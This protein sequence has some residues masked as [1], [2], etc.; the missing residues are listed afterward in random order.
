MDSAFA[1]L[2]KALLRPFSERPQDFSQAALLLFEV[3]ADSRHR[4]ADP[5]DEQRS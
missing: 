1:G 4:L 3:I 2:R 5:N